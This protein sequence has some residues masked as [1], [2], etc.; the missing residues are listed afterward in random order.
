MMDFKL[1]NEWIVCLLSSDKTNTY[2]TRTLV[3]KKLEIVEIVSQQEVE[4]RY[5]YIHYTHF[6]SPPWYS[7]YCTVLF[8]EWEASK[9]RAGSPK[10]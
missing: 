5:L 8:D 3:P 1:F 10:L 7:M 2:S 4:Y 6:N 9:E